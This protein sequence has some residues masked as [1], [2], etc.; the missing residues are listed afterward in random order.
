MCGLISYNPSSYHDFVEF[1]LFYLFYFKR[2]E[3]ICAG[4]YDLIE[5]TEML[6]CL[7]HSSGT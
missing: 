3:V 2:D 7:R 4:N 5:S 1:H 6:Q